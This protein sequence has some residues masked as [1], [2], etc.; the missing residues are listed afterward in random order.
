M[1]EIV[2]SSRRV[3][4][5]LGVVSQ[6]SREESEGIHQI[7]QAVHDLDELT[8]QNAALVEE[9]AAAAAAMRDQA[10]KLAREVG[11]FQLA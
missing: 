5:L 3:D 8:Q 6:G 1:D 2:A 10:D 11:R 9:T 4:E 7:G